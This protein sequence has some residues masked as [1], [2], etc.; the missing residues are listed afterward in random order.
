MSE[1]SITQILHQLQRAENDEQRDAAAALLFRVYRQQV[2]RVARG[3]LQPGGGL[4]DEE[5]VAQSAFRSFFG[6]IETGQLDAL[7]SGGQAWAILARLTRNKAIDSVRYENAQCRGGE[8]GRRKSK[9][10]EVV[11]D[12]PTSSK[13]TI[14][15]QNASLNTH[16]SLGKGKST[17]SFPVARNRLGI[18]DVPEPVQAPAASDSLTGREP[19]R[20]RRRE[21]VPL[22]AVRDRTQRSGDELVASNEAI[23]YFLEQLSEATLR[24]IVAL[25]MDGFT[26]EEIAEQ[27]GCATRTVE[28]KLNLI[29]RLWIPILE[30]SDEYRET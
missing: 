6:R 26:N 11:E 3:R 7:V 5:D 2:E 19:S 12:P 15:D 30:S 27:L 1:S 20:V 14:A 8:G 18:E 22:E 17:K 25:K 28:R 24:G 16:R 4:S 23:E 10:E 21:E 13:Q 9:T 29:R